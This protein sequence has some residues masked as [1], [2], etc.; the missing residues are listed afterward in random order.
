M[1]AISTNLRKW[2]SVKLGYKVQPL[3]YVPYQGQAICHF[4]HRHEA[5]FSVLLKFRNFLSYWNL[6][7]TVIVIPKGLNNETLLC[8]STNCCV[9]GGFY[10]Y[11]RGFFLVWAF[12]FFFFFLLSPL[13]LN[14]KLWSSSIPHLRGIFSTDYSVLRMFSLVNSRHFLLQR[15]HCN[16]QILH[17]GC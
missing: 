11:L 15:N 10:I 17:P 2:K 14:S 12:N 9:L 4:S 5:S 1:I 8:F 3:Q 7:I 16:S 13:L 6:G